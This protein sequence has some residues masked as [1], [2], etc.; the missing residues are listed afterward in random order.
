L[1]RLKSPFVV[2]ALILE[3]K[4]NQQLIH[5]S[6]MLVV[7]ALILEGKNNTDLKLIFMRTGC[8]CP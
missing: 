4:N 3:G 2:V 7:A 5:V 8:S 1:I 6:A